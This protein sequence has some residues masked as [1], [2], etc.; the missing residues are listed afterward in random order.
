MRDGFDFDGALKDLFQQDR[1][2]LLDRLTGGVAVLE[3]LNVELPRIQERRVDLLLLLA[4]GS[5]LHL[6]FQ[7]KN[8]AE[9][10]YRMA[11][12]H[13]LLAQ[14]YRGRPMRHVVLYVGQAR[15]RMAR[16]LDTGPLQFTFELMDIREIE[17]ADLLQSRNAADFVLAIL[18]G[19]GAGRLR[20]IVER[21][22]KL[23]GSAKDRALAQLVVLSGLRS[24]PRELEVELAQMGIVID[25]SKNVI[26][27]RL[28]REAIEE[29][30]QA[31]MQAGMQEGRQAGR[32][33]ILREQIETKF[34]RLPQ[35]ASA[36][37]T[38]ASTDQVKE[39]SRKVLV[40]E[41]IEAVLGK[42]I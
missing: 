21:I 13:L 5:I 35:W 19:G 33:S 39:W 15:M 31:G 24:L 41:S 27:Q 25:G 6:E 28:R 42:R 26:L 16:R 3:F 12:Y 18:A 2:G 29:G 1:P 37:L 36:R 20:E 38:K 7:S 34:G 14:R 32:R 40:G 10:A 30:M 23:K 11:M 17:S 8:H 22:A 9:M 4:D